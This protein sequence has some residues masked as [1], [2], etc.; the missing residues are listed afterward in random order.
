MSLETS[1]PAVRLKGV[2]AG[3]QGR[4]ALEDVSFDVAE[5]AFTALIGPN[6]AGKSTC[7]KLLLGLV[8]PLAGTVE[9]FGRNA[10]SSAGTIGYVPQSVA[11]PRGVPISVVEVALMGRYGAL[12]PG[13]RPKAEDR[14]RVRHALGQVHS[15]DLATRRFQDLSGGQ[16]QRVLIARALCS[17]SRL[18]LLDEPTAGLDSG[19]RARFYA[20]VCDLQHAEGLTLLCATHDLDVVGDHADNIILLNRTVRANGPSREVLKSRAM[21]EA[22]PLPKTH[23]HEHPP[24]PSDAVDGDGLPR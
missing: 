2:R 16:Q 22:Y 14:D 6:G 12:G 7:L 11:I 20:L 1:T 23:T 8:R 15:E 4:P 17:D 9:V 10:A 24:G 19:A 21:G 13:R 5:G 3:Y 18:L